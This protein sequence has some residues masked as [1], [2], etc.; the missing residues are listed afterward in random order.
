M[1]PCDRCCGDAFLVEA[2]FTLS[3]LDAKRWAARGELVYVIPPACR[4]HVPA[5]Q[6]IRDAV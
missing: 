4:E 3:V 6:P 1:P 5:E 2:G